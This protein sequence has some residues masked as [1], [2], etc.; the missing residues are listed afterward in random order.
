MYDQIYNGHWHLYLYPQNSEQFYEYI[1]GWPQKHSR[2]PI[3]VPCSL[4]VVPCSLSGNMVSPS[5]QCFDFILPPYLDLQKED[6]L[7]G[8]ANSDCGKGSAKGLQQQVQDVFKYW[9]R[10][11]IKSALSNHEEI[12][13]LI[14]PG[15]C[16]RSDI[17]QMTACSY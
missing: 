12:K 10:N 1:Q 17:H 6:V 16:S 13:A 4:E 15:T 11:G 7:L 5:V 14:N 9:F 2:S 8:T 3:L